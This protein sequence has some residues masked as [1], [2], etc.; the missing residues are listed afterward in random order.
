MRLLVDANLSPHVAEGLRSAGFD[1]AHVADLGLLTAD[2][3]ACGALSRPATSPAG[4][5]VPS[6]DE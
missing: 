2:D 6:A 3:D 5:P 4:A 1:A